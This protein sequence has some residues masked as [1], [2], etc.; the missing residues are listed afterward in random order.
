MR[1]AFPDDDM[2]A[3][4]VAAVASEL[5]RALR[6]S[7]SWGKALE[8]E[9]KAWRRSAFPSVGGGAADRRLIY[10]PRENGIDV[11]MF[12]HDIIPT[13]QAYILALHGAFDRAARR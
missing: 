10:R 7:K 3:S 9:L 4:A 8:S 1:F 12:G 11:L 6:A 2:F 5:A 13:R